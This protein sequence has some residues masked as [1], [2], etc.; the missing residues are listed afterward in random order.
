MPDVQSFLR[1]AHEPEATD[2]Q[3]DDDWNDREDQ[4]DEEL[5]GVAGWRHREDDAHDMLPPEH[6]ADEDREE[7]HLRIRSSSNDEG[8]VHRD[9]H[10]LHE[11]P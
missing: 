11:V 1:H 10:Q 4:E 6:D 5:Q 8:R 2:H 3:R 7:L 9:Y